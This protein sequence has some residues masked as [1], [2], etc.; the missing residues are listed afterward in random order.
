MSLATRLALLTLFLVWMYTFCLPVQ[1]PVYD[2]SYWSEVD[3]KPTTT[4]AHNVCDTGELLTEDYTCV[5]TSF[6]N[7]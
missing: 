3:N 5:P 2:H 6:Y 7:N 1:T 4:F